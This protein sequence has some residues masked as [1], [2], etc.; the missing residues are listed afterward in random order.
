MKHGRQVR[1][2]VN[3]LDSGNIIAYSCLR[4]QQLISFG[5]ERMKPFIVVLAFLGVLAAVAGAGGTKEIELTDGSVLTGEVVSLTG[6]VYTIKSDALGTVRIEESKVRS[7]RT[8]DAPGAAGGTGA[9]VKSLQDKM[10]G[11]Q[12]IMNMIKSL[13]D[14][15]DFQK[16]LQDPEVMKAVNSGDVATLMSNPQFKKL[17]DNKTV[18]EIQNKVKK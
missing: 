17:L 4:N 8:K 14:D 11:D 2:G 1:E 13:Q 3:E 15:P 5:S 18:Q 12:E 9:Q 10:T 16:V 7:I 6:G